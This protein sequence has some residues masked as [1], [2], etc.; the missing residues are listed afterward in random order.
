MTIVEK[1]KE[2]CPEGFDAY[3]FVSEVYNWPLIPEDEDD[4]LEWLDVE[5]FFIKELEEDYMIVICGG[6]W[7]TPYEV[8]VELLD[9]NLTVTYNKEIDDYDYE[10]EIEIEY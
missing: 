5:N 1:I 4:T 3:E 2:I 8:K 7:Q 10:N 9:D 6:D